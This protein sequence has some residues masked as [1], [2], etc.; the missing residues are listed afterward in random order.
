MQIELRQDVVD[1]HAHSRYA[2]HQFGRDFAR[3]Q[4]V[5]QQRSDL[6]L[7]PSQGPGVLLRRVQ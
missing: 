2:D 6:R 3:R 1:V 7:P 4:A 5:R